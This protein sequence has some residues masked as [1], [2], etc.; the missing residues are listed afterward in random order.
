M[1][2]LRVFFDDDFFVF[3]FIFVFV[4][5]VSVFGNFGIDGF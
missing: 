5:V 2:R 1:L 4:G 3:F